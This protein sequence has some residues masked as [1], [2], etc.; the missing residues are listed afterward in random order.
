MLSERDK[1]KI[2]RAIIAAVRRVEDRAHPWT[3]QDL[4]FLIQRAFKVDGMK[5]ARR[6][7][8]AAARDERPF[9]GDCDG[10]GTVEGGAALETTC[11]KCKGT[12]REPAAV[13]P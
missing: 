12:G 1:A 3:E 6:R 13:A 9:C 8:R 4:R 5:R 7:A 11:T 10:C 2:E